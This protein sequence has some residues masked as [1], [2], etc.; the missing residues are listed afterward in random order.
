MRPRDK[1][2]LGEPVTNA[3]ERPSGND[4]RGAVEE[5]L[6]AMDSGGFDLDIDAIDRLNGHS[7]LGWPIP[8]AD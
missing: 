7:R 8:D 3:Q 6:T 1:N 5:L 4:R 2:N